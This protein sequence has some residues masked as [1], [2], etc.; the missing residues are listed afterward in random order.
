MFKHRQHLL[1][2]VLAAATLTAAPAQAQV[3]SATVTASD[4]VGM[5][6]VGTD[7]DNNVRITLTNSR[8]TI[9][10]VVPV[11]AGIGC[12]AVAGDP[13]QATCFAP[14][15]GVKFK[16]FVA[17][18]G[19]GNDTVVNATS[20]A[21]VEGAP[22]Q[23]NGSVG[24]DVLVGDSKTDDVLSGSTGDDELRDA[25]GR[26]E[27]TGSSGN[28]KLVGGFG[29]DELVGG[30]DNDVLDG[31]L[32]SDKLFGGSGNDQLQGGGSD[33]QLDGGLGADT[34]DGGQTG[35]AVGERH[36]VVIY[37][38][39]TT[40]VHVNLKRTD[41]TQGTPANPALGVPAEGDTIVDVEDV[42]S[43]NGK[44]LL[45]GNEFDNNL[46]GAGGDDVL[47]GDR[48]MDR[49]LGGDDNDSIFPS[50][51]PS[52][53][54]PFGAVRD[55]VS[56]IIDCGGLSA[57]DGDPGD[58]AFRVVLDQDFANDCATVILQ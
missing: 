35:I 33:D 14:K 57:G 13:T 29:L 2:G 34:I 30:P 1:L 17:S 41:A 25:G 37:S 40:P 9:D 39:R 24:N 20:T 56:D 16:G 18:A 4:A 55:F 48:G 3:P 11:T 58:Q 6:Y 50:P 52:I 47:S 7:A 8:F 46:S 26:N 12:N 27:L 45:I 31:A 36:D 38:S 32:N 22:M 44:D 49:L 19:A 53:Q 5:R 15:V 23:A 42:S 28:D 54:V 10:D 43:G 21:T 51:A